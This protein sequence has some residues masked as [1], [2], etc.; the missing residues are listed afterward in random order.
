MYNLFV[1][2]ELDQNDIVL[3]DHDIHINDKDLVVQYEPDA[4]DDH[5]I[6]QH[7]VHNLNLQYNVY[8]YIDHRPKFIDTINENNNNNI[9]EYTLPGVVILPFNSSSVGIHRFA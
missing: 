1:H 5:D 3:H 9:K 7:N 2:I 6:N 4:M 8:N